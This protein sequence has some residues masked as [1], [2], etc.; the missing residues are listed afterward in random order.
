[1]RDGG[2]REE[3]PK[4]DVNVERIFR[5]T[6]EIDDGQLDGLNG[7]NFHGCPV[8]CCMDCGF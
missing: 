1:M 6:G 3:N 8:P 2:N 4:P 5:K 7:R